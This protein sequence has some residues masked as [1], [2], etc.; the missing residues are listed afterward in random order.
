MCAHEKNV[1]FN[2]YDCDERRRRRGIRE[3]YE[4]MLNLFG[5]LSGRG[6]QEEECACDSDSVHEIFRFTFS[7]L[8]CVQHKES[9]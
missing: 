9:H 6:G 8:M 1:C 3:S 4:I 7:R 2:I 5:K